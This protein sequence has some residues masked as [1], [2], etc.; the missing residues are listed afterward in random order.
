MKHTIGLM[1]LLDPFNG[2]ST[3]QTQRYPRP[4]DQVA[5]AQNRSAFRATIITTI[6][7]GTPRPN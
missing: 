1:Y 6:F 5:A 2:K 7:L 4:I 3:K